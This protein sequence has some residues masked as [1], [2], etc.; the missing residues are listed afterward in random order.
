MVGDCFSDDDGENPARGLKFFLSEAEFG[1]GDRK[2]PVFVSSGLS[3]NAADGEAG[4]DGIAGDVGGSILFDPFL[5]RADRV[6]NGTRISGSVLIF[7]KAGSSRL[8]DAT[9]F[10]SQMLGTAVNACCSNGFFFGGF[11]SSSLTYCSMKPIFLHTKYART[12]DNRSDSTMNGK[13]CNINGR[14][15]F[16]KPSSLV[17]VFKRSSNSSA[18]CRNSW[19][20]SKLSSHIALHRRLQ[21]FH[22]FSN[23][24]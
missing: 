5:K 1:R 15:S 9:A 23:A 4:S 6:D 14:K 8:T 19:R 3:S 16:K 22:C 13:H 21:Y 24:T 12:R 20:S 17:F 10:G 11:G 7:N 18:H 2:L